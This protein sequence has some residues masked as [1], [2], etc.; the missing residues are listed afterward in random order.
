MVMPDVAE[1]GALKGKTQSSWQWG[2]MHLSG[3]FG[4]C[5]GDPSTQAV[6]LLLLCGERVF[7]GIAHCLGHW[8]VAPGLYPECCSPMGPKVLSAAR[9]CWEAL[10]VT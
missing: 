2:L 3:S 6:T 5:S 4:V 9:G 1:C 10:L 8:R 7:G